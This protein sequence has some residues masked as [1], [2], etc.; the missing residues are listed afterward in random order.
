MKRFFITAFL[1][2]PLITF[3]QNYWDWWNQLHDY[4]NAAGPNRRRYINITPGYMGPN[5]LPVVRLFNAT[6]D[7]NLWLDVQWQ[8]HDGRG[9]STQNLFARINIPVAKDRVNLYIMSVPYES[10]E[11]NAFVRDERRMMNFAARGAD[12][13]D[14]LFGVNIMSL[15][16]EKHFVNAMLN[17]EIKT[18]TGSGLENARY[19]DHSMYTFGGHFGKTLIKA[20]DQKLQIKGMLGF[21]TWQTN[22]NNLP[23]GS[24]HLQN[25][26]YLFGMG[27][28]WKSE[29]WEIGSDLSGYT[30][31]IDNR[32][33]PL[34]WRNQIQYKFRRIAFR[35]EYEHGLRWWSW[36]STSLGLRYYF[37]K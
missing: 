29:H 6:Y 25:D 37:T 8:W 14:I 33:D 15:N 26:A 19:T 27:M 30:G 17:V 4:P 11:T 20:N 13:G 9:E 23:G 21:V 2:M 1:L 22:Q 36:N 32:D 28:E 35:L 31:Y 24:N 10:W 5:A 3:G 7:P 16:E 34:F 18:T 12:T